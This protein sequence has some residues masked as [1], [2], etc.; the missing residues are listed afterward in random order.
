M[1]GRDYD[2]HRY[3]MNEQT[4]VT[5][6]LTL[7]P[8]QDDSVYLAKFMVARHQL[9]IPADFTVSD[10]RICYVSYRRTM[11]LSSAFEIDAE[12]ELKK[13]ISKGKAAPLELPPNKKEQA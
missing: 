12:L 11:K 6:L 5:L 13:H 2:R 3:H 8:P 4:L 7:G 9:G 1:R 10:W